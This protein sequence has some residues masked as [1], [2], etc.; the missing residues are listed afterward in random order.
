MKRQTLAMPNATAMP[1]TGSAR[2]SWMARSGSTVW[3]ITA[4]GYNDGDVAGP[5]R[6]SLGD[7]QKV[8]DKGCTAIGMTGRIPHDLRRSGVKHYIDADVDPHTVIAWSGHRTPSILRHYHIIDLEDLR[9]AGP[10]AGEYRG[11]ESN[12]R[13][14]VRPTV[15]EP[16]QTDANSGPQDAAVVAEHLTNPQIAERL[17]VSRGTVKTH[18]SHIYSKLGISSRAELTDEIL[19]HQERL[20]S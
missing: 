5:G 8:W 16:S 19:R 1:M 7:F 17:F 12:V 2:I 4:R 11:P 18:L 9:R 10:R 15:P 14:L 13:P 6:P 3:S 20:R